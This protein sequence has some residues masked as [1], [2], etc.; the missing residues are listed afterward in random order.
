MRTEMRTSVRALRCVAVAAAVLVAGSAWAAE[1]PAEGEG[2]AAA[3]AGANWQH[4]R[5]DND[6]T[7]MA[8]LQRGA[9]N[10]IGYCLGCHSLKYVRWSRMGADLDDPAGSAAEDLIP[11]GDKDTQYILTQHARG[12]CGELVRQDAAGSVADRPRARP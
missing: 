8:S 7:D 4:W 5:S 9:R 12:G 11:P 3:K 6:V 2:E 10:F 1:A